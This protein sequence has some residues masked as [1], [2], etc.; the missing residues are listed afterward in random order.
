MRGGAQLSHAGAAAQRE[1][2]DFDVGLGCSGLSG[3]RRHCR[4]G[5]RAEMRRATS[6]YPIARREE[7]SL[8]CPS[9]CTGT[10]GELR[11]LGA[12]WRAT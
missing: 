1:M 6:C 4:Q 8:P 11:V 9:Y 10:A 12:D 2:D 7:V 5:R 3:S